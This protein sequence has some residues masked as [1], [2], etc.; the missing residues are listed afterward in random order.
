MLHRR[1]RGIGWQLHGFHLT[2]FGFVAVLAWFGGKRLASLV[3]GKGTVV[4]VEQISGVEV[5]R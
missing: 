3:V 5:A 4:P 2:G 1:M